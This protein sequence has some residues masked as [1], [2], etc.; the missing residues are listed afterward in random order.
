ML[1]LFDYWRPMSSDLRQYLWA[2]RDS[3]V[4]RARRLIEMLSPSQVVSILRYLVADYW[5][6]YLGWP[7]LLLQRGRRNS[8]GRGQ[9]I[10]RPAERKPEALDRRQP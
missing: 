3:E 10:E 9:V 6:H 1:W 5:G 8:A 2:H 4:A 7:D